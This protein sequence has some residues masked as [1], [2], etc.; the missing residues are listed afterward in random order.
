M[1]E[2]YEVL[3]EAL[4]AH[5]GKVDRIAGQVAQAAAAGHQMSLPS[6]AYGE[7]CTDLPMVINPMQEMGAL[8]LSACAKHLNTVASGIRA[9]A[10]RY[11]TVEAANELAVQRAMEV[12]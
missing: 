8:A 6:D 5:A 11:A 12:R 1:A 2:E 10:Q 9:S 3:T 7:F 4:L